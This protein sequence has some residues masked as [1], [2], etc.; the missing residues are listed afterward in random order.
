MKKDK[1]TFL[2]SDE[3]K[4]QGVQPKSTREAKSCSPKPTF[5]DGPMGLSNGPP[6]DLTNQPEAQSRLVGGP[7]QPRSLPQDVAPI[8]YTSLGLANDNLGMPLGLLG[9]GYH[10][11]LMGMMGGFESRGL[12]GLMGDPLLGLSNPRLGMMGFRMQ[13]MMQDR[14]L[15]AMRS[16]LLER[17]LLERAM[18][19][20]ALRERTLGI[21]YFGAGALLQAK[22]ALSQ[23][24]YAG[25]TSLGTNSALL[26]PHAEPCNTTPKENSTEAPAPPIK[27]EMNNGENGSLEMG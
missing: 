13:S 15:L 22:R 3:N 10:Y 17:E 25:A 14:E 8:S 6:A 24:M 18:A 5:Q 4:S 16:R 19:E 11:G 26:P 27:A 2:K 12:Q 21:N 9:G 7:T 20:R 23:Q 1:G